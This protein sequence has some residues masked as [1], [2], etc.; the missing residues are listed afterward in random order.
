MFARHHY[1]SGSLS[2]AA[3][4]FVA[5]WDGAPVAFWLVRR[6][7]AVSSVVEAFLS[8]PLVLPP[9]VVGYFLLVIL[10]PQGLIGGWL[11]RV[12]LRSTPDWQGAVCASA[13]LAFQLFFAFL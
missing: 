5:F 7:G 11:E 3:R 8:L 2:T 10:R 4:C 1:L 9:V 13:L 6:H 12:G